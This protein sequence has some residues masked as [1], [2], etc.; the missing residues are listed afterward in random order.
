MLAIF[1]SFTED[2]LILLV[3]FLLF[4]RRFPEMA[5]NIGRKLYQFRRGVD[6]L[7]QELTKPI[8]EQL[9]NPVREMA[10][11]ARGV[12]RDVESD[13]R[14]TA[15]KAAEGLSPSAPDSVHHADPE[16]GLGRPGSSEEPGA[17]AASTEQAPAARPFSYP[18][19]VPTAALS[20]PAA[21]SGNVADSGGSAPPAA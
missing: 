11:A 1:G 10:E 18:G 2:L 12:V 4:G 3:A 6:D 14:R 9:Q 20:R 7:K 16:G 15:Q 8:R 19:I 13:V 17:G 5:G 21:E